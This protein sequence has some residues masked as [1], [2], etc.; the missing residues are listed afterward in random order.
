MRLTFISLAVL[1]VGLPNIAFAHA[2]MRTAV[3]RVGSTVPAPSEIAINYTEGVDPNLSSI[4]VHDAS[5]ARVDKMDLR[6]AP[7]NPTRLTVGVVPLK[8]GTYKVIWH[9][10]SLTAHKTEGYYTFVVGEGR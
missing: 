6:T 8:P 9:A 1:A 10:T 5:G 7:G 2:H 3:P 4:T